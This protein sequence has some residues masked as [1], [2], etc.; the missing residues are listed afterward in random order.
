MA[1]AKDY[2]WLLPFI[3]TIL[4]GISFFTPAAFGRTEA[5]GFTYST[6]IWMTGFTRYGSG[7]YIELGFF[8]EPLGG[9]V[10]LGVI[11]PG[12][13]A[14]IFL[15]ICTII[16]FVSSLTHRGKE[17]PGSW[18]AF[19]ILLI[20]GAIYYIAG[21]EIGFA[22]YMYNEGATEHV[23][24]WTDLDYNPGFAVIAPFIGGGLTLLGAIIGKAIGRG[25]VIS[26]PKAVPE[27]EKPIPLVE[28]PTPAPEE[29]KVVRFCSECGTKIEQADATFCAVC[30]HKF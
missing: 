13:I 20:A 28:T 2:I 30:G 26:K 19:G 27:V 29:I 4:V 10:I 23:S 1:E 21:V 24:F 17:T 15:T 8:A 12:I 11:I 3:G 5:Y 7:D 22:T 25:E 16:T 6:F 9:E 14:L 18:I